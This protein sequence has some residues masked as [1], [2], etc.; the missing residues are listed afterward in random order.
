MSWDTEIPIITRSLIGDLDETSYTD[1]RLKTLTVVG[2]QVLLKEIDF[3][4]T[5]TV[6]VGAE[7]ISPDPTDSPRDDAFI[8]L[9]ALKTA[10]II[11]GSEAKTA[12]NAGFLVTDGPSTVDT[13]ARATVLKDLAKEACSAYANAKVSYIVNGRAGVAI[14][15]P[16]TNEGYFP[17]I[18]DNFN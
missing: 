11:N 8:T 17:T 6:N 14:L 9:V 3:G 18:N 2:A 15:T 12:A 10:C 1:A 5:Y 4:N 7:T 13:R 16:Y